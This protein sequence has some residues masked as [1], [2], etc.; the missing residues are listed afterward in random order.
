MAE[1]MGPS[2]PPHAAEVQPPIS[3]A[4]VTDFCEPPPSP[5]SHTTTGTPSGDDLDLAEE[6]EL[7]QG[8]AGAAANLA[9]TA[10]YPKPSKGRKRGRSQKFCIV[11]DCG[12]SVDKMPIWFRKTKCCMKHSRAPEVTLYGV[13]QRLCQKCSRFHTLDKFDGLLRSCREKLEVRHSFSLSFTQPRPATHHLSPVYPSTDPS[14]QPVSSFSTLFYPFSTLQLHNEAR[15]KRLREEKEAHEAMRMGVGVGVGAEGSNGS[16]S[17]AGATVAPPRW[18]PV[19]VAAQLQAYGV[20]AHESAMAAAAAAISELAA[21]QQ[22][23]A[24]AQ[25]GRPVRHREMEYKE[26][27]MGAGGQMGGPGGGAGT[28]SFPR[29]GVKRSRTI[30]PPTSMGD[31][32]S[33][34]HLP[35][36]RVAAPVAMAP[37]PPPPAP[38][39]AAPAPPAGGG[40]LLAQLVAQLQQVQQQGGLHPPSLP[41]GLLPPAPPPQHQAIAAVLAAAQAQQ[42]QHAANLANLNTLLR[43]LCNGGPQ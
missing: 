4:K 11:D 1:V 42:R 21:A 10:A 8:L 43:V 30:T 34:F 20:E 15:K 22:A 39:P 29:W 7:L 14:Y 3:N 13:S 37:P 36:P 28:A 32:P 24:V 23:A 2:P 16:A 6:A 41:A 40:D 12:V 27:Q 17:T 26:E 9:G 25:Q 31:G 38:A 18:A 19:D 35:A 5:P 33:A